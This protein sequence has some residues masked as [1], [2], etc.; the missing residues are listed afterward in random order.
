MP[1]RPNSSDHY[2]AS[3]AVALDRW[4]NEGGA[5]RG[6]GG[7]RCDW[8]TPLSEGRS[9]LQCLGAP[10]FSQC[11]DLPA[12]IQRELFEHYFDAAAGGDAA[13]LKKRIARF[14]HEHKDDAGGAQ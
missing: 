1:T 7:E 4:E 5:I 13:R 14:Q 12:R 2:S 8:R 9:I 6:P 11:D 3:Q 10:V